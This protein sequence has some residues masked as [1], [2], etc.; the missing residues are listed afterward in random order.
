MRALDLPEHRVEIPASRT[1]SR[2]QKIDVLG[3]ERHDD[4]LTRDVVAALPRAVEQIAP[5]PAPFPVGGRE[6]D[7]LDP[8]VTLRTIHLDAHAAGARAPAHELGVV[9]GPRRISAR[10]QVDRF[11][12]IGLSGAVRSDEGGDS[13]AEDLP[14]VGVGAKVLER[15]IADPHGSG[16]NAQRH[17][18]VKITVVSDDLDHARRQRP[19]KLES[20]LRRGHAAER[21]RDET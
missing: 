16:R 10:G 11:Q 18:H 5:R 6:Q 3:K 1:R 15:Q 20:D 14:H 12:E 9:M 19:T 21:V 4:Q 17:H 2:A 8:A 7:E 13:A